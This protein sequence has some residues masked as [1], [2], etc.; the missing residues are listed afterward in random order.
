VPLKNLAK[1]VKKEVK[2]ATKS[3]EDKFVDSIDKFILNRD[4]REGSKSIKPSSYYNCTRQVWYNLLDYP[5]KHKP[6]ARG[7]RILDVGTA[8]HEY[9]QGEVLMKM[10]DISL[11]PFEE[12]PVYGVEGVEFIKEHSSSPMEVKVRDYRFTKKYP[13]SYMVDG[14][15]EFG[16]FRYIFE[17]KTINTKDFQFLFEPLKDHLM[18]GAVYSLSLGIRKVLFLY[19]D[20]NDQNFKAYEHTYSDEE[21]D[22]CKAKV[23]EIEKYLLDLKLPEKEESYKCKYCSF[24]TFCANNIE[25]KEYEEDEN[26]FKKFLK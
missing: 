12:I 24:K 25:A 7:M 20:K 17:F 18:Q 5:A 9:I 22:F 10:G 8:I 15:F 16:G 23:L 14:L 11:V 2:E 4:M 26:G 19:M 6:S 21:L 1:R 3:T 13:L